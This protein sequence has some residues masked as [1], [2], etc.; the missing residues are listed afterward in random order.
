MVWAIINRHYR[1][2]KI[3][4]VAFPVVH[5]GLASSASALDI[6]KVQA[7]IMGSA[8]YAA[9]LEFLDERPHHAL[10]F[11]SADT[12]RSGLWRSAIATSALMVCGT[13]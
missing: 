7:E 8:V 4:A 5:V 1:R 11:S 13:A 3:K 2:M 9:L 6:E 10:D 12:R